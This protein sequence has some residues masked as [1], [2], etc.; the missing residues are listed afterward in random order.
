M[1]QPTPT[2]PQPPAGHLLPHSP[3]TPV[4]AG[5]TAHRAYLANPAQSSGA[6]ALEKFLEKYYTEDRIAHAINSE[7][8]ARGGFNIKFKG[9]QVGT[10]WLHSSEQYKAVLRLAFLTEDRARPPTL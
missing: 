4:A 1:P 8:G 6:T 9:K 2:D 3:H 10:S 7:T 5:R